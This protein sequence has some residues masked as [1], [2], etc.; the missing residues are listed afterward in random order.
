LILF[1]LAA[2]CAFVYYIVWE[3]LLIRWL[4]GSYFA[5]YKNWWHSPKTDPWITNASYFNALIN[6]PIWALAWFVMLYA[7]IIGFLMIIILV[8]HIIF[9]VAG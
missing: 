6:W 8:A 4:M 1:R 5:L 9:N 2:L 7:G 3:R